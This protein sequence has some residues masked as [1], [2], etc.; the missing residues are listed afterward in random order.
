VS[1]GAERIHKDLDKRQRHKRSLD[2]EAQEQ[3]QVVQAVRCQDPGEDLGQPVDDEDHVH[4]GEHGIRDEHLALRI[5][6]EG[7][8]LLPVAVPEKDPLQVVRAVRDRLAAQVGDFQQVADEVV[9]VKA[10]QG[11]G[12]EE[13]RVDARHEHGIEREVPGESVGQGQPQVRGDGREV[14]FN[15][16]PG[17]RREDLVPLVPHH[18][19]V[20]RID[21]SARGKTHQT[22][23]HF[24]HL[25]LRTAGRSWRARTRGRS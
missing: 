10:H 9:P 7:R 20:R 3:A 6:T 17:D 23:P 25:A 13:Q 16:D 21:V 4:V 19:R 1:S 22:H 24:V 15:E 12:I 5:V 18:P 14:Q 11:I 2:K 8:L